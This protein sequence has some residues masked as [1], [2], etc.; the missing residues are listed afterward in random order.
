MSD[1]PATN[2]APTEEPKAKTQD[3]H[4]AA[5][6]EH[7]PAPAPEVAS[8]EAQ[9]EGEPA[10]AEVADE[11]AEQPAAAEAAEEAPV[12]SVPEP[13]VPNQ[14]EE[15]EGAPASAAE[16]AETADGPAAGLTRDAEEQP[17]ET[18]V[19]EQPAEPAEKPAKPKRTR[20]KKAEKADAE[21]PTDT[22]TATAVATEAPA[23][24]PADSKKK[25]YAIKVQ[26]GREESI[27]AAIL[28]KVAI[29]GLEQYLGRIEIP[30]E[31]EIV[32]KAVRVK[33]KKTG[34]YTTQEKKV[35]KKKIKFH[36]YIFAELEFNDRI[37]YLFRETGGVGDF[38][39]MRGKPPVP[40]PMPDHEVRAML[41]GEKTVDP[42]KKPTKIKI[43]FEKG[44]RVRIREGAFA[45]SEGEVKSITEPK[46]PTDSPKVKVELTFWGRPLEV[47]LD[48]WQ[49]EKV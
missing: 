13:V 20:K 43:D 14:L 22:A 5:T 7:Q 41:T 21:A 40:E 27:K 34:E 23:E 31:E 10:P 11:P 4:E 37:L 8:T 28:R 32:K 39:S 17:A 30:V 49:V 1:D 36:G 44:D 42:S 25:W 6:T 2:A 29:E 24:A 15:T 18:P 26:S 47:D 45:N 9:S 3:Q 16:Q 33:D 19:A 46:D 12:E 48:H 38:L 35:T